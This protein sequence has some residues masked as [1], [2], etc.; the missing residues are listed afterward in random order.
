VS[1]EVPIAVIT[2]F[3]GYD[4]HGTPYA[5]RGVEKLRG[6]ALVETR[7]DCGQ[8]MRTIMH[9]GSGLAVISAHGPSEPRDGAWALLAS[10]D[11]TR[12]AV[13]L[14]TDRPTAQVVAR[15]LQDETLIVGDTFMHVPLRDPV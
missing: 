7:C 15:L 4:P 1:P 11:W 14:E 10:V 6:L 3:I 8:Q 5:V 2:M 12:P 13:E 9:I